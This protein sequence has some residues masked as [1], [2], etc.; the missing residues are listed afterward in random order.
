M[1]RWLLLCLA[2]LLVV[3][4]GFFQTPAEASE[5]V[6]PETN[7]E[8]FRDY[9]PDGGDVIYVF[10]DFDSHDVYFRQHF[11][12]PTIGAHLYGATEFLR[13]ES[14][15]PGGSTYTGNN[16]HSGT[17]HYFQYRRTCSH[18]TP[19]FYQWISANCPG[20]GHCISPLDVIPSID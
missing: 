7:L 1:K 4:V 3:F 13:T 12:D 14:H 2:L 18:C 19:V 10:K 17:K 5:P 15:T 16:Y 11:Y 9:Q 8:G 20:N 6:E